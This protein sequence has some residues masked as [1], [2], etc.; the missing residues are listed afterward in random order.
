MTTAVLFQERFQGQHE[1]IRQKIAIFSQEIK[2]KK[3]PSVISASVRVELQRKCNDVFFEELPA[4]P[5][6][7]PIWEKLNALLEKG[8]Y[9]SA[10]GDW[11][12]H[13]N[14][15]KDLGRSGDLQEEYDLRSVRSSRQGDS[16]TPGRNR[17]VHA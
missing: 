10:A 7:S 12:D 11:A 16:G 14:W 1:D 3:M 2:D 5:P 9:F 13:K 17:R 4:P 15:E 8:K 6:D